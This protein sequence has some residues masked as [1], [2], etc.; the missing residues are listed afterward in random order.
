M[1]SHP[2]LILLLCVCVHSQAGSVRG[3]VPATAHLVARQRLADQA[4]AQVHGEAR[5]QQGHPAGE[6]RQRRRRR[7]VLV[8]GHQRPGRGRL[9]HD[10]LRHW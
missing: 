10:A 6:E 2:L 3:G 5:G 8:Q 9:Q 7:H 1:A 4:V